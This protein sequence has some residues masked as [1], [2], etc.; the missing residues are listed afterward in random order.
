MN[1]TE[2]QSEI[3]AFSEPRRAAFIDYAR[4]LRAI[5]QELTELFPKNLVIETDGTN[6]EAHGESHANPFHRVPESPLKRFLNRMFGRKAATTESAMQPAA[7]FAR[8]YSAEDIERL[9]QL[10]SARRS[11]GVRKRPDNY[12]L[13]ERL[14]TMGGIV[15]A[16][17]GRLKQVCKTADQF[18]AEY[19]D[20]DGKLRS[21]KLTTVILYRNQSYDAYAA[22]SQPKELWE[23][24]DF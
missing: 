13:A 5:G 3:A 16:R 22:S 2:A 15:K 14:R 23:G 7:T 4:A 1:V 10:Y 9:D 6:F 17:N 18:V 12:S 21:A 20:V 11:P 8:H 24:Y 19:W